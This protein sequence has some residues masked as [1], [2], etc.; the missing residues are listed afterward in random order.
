MIY[1]VV[2]IGS[3]LAGLNS[4]LHAS[5]YGRVLVITKAKLLESNSRYAQG[6][7]AAVFQHHDSFQ[8]HIKDTLIAGAYHN[9]KKAV[10]YFVEQAPKI[11]TMLQKQGVHFEKTSHGEFLQNQEAGHEYRRIV[12]AGDHTGLSIMQVVAQKVLADKNITVWENSFAKDLIVNN[13]TCRGVLAIHKKKYAVV[14]A[15]RIII[16]TGGVGQLYEY[17]TNPAVT[18][19]DGIALAARAGCRIRDMEFIQFHPTAFAEDKSPLFLISETVRGEGAKLL[20]SKGQRFMTKYH[21]SAELAPRDVVSRAMY[22]EQKKGPVYLDIRHKSAQELREKFPT[23]F[24]YLKKHG[25]DL[26]KDLVPVTPAAHYLC[27]GIVT[28]VRGKTNIT[29]LYAL[30]E[31][32][33]TGLQGAN[34]LASNSL[35]EAGVMSEHVM[36]DPLPQIKKTHSL[37]PPISDFKMASKKLSLLRKKLQKSMWINVGIIRTRNL[38]TNAKKQIREIQKQLPENESIEKFELQDMLQT[39]GM[40][41]EAALKRKKSLGAHYRKN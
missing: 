8:K 6:G 2:I 17:T 7:I 22:E 25:Y 30:G 15:R 20:N 9:D 32:T 18:T 23:I 5:K 1:D 14:L 26:S 41:I 13:K 40:I 28:N 12:H 3:G 31:V 21:K 19:G 10:K 27:G 29:N 24:K 11:I 39:S 34:R 16:A 35:L 33:C 38:L 36:D 4:A 37:V